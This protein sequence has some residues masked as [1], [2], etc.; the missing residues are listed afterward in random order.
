MI[1]PSAEPT[2]KKTELTFPDKYDTESAFWNKVVEREYSPTDNYRLTNQLN[3]QELFSK[4]TQFKK[5]VDFFG[6]ISGKKILDAACG[7]G[8]ASLYF[9]RSGGIVY[10]FDI[11]E[12]SIQVAKRFAMNNGLDHRIYAEVMP[13]EYLRY[14]NEFFDF[15]FVNA[16]VHHCNIQRVSSE[17]YRVLKPGGKVAIIEDYG[18]HPFLNIYRYL[19]PTRRTPHEKALKREDVELFIKR[20]SCVEMEYY[21]LLDILDRSW[22]LKRF[23]NRL[24][25]ILLKMFPPL[26][27]YC[28]L[29]G[30]YA[31]K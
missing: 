9:A 30:I 7:V 28:R 1:L 13:A 22:F 12:K 11:S 21:Q 15:V 29:I 16:A 5:I 2:R 6:D 26:K 14:D 17:F 8:W 3:Y 31:V 25:E 27:K 4:I 23:L 20:F 19:T 24:D 18:Y 10:C